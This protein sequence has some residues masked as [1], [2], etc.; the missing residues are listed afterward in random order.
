[1]RSL[2][3]FALSLA[4][5]S[6][7]AGGGVAADLEGLKSRLQDAHAEG[8]DWWVYND[9]E[10]A[11]ETAR[12]LNKPLFVTFRCI[13][14]KDCQA[15]DAEVAKGNEQIEAL[16]REKFVPVRQV[17]MK[18][19]DLSQFQFDYDLNWAAMFIHPD[20][21]VYA[22]YGTQSAEGADAY[23]S[24][25]GLMS[26]MRRVL[27][28]HAAYPGNKDELAAKRGKAKPYKTALEMSGLEN[29]EK[30]RGET[31]RNNCI[32]CH[33]IH[34]AEHRQAWDEGQYSHD[35]LWR[36]PLPENVGLAI[37]A[38]HGVRI[39]W[40]QPGSPAAK[41]GLKAGEDVT[42]MNGQAITSIADM[43]WVLHNLPNTDE[44]AVTVRGSRTG[45]RPL[46]LAAGW[47]KS[48]ISWRGSLWSAPP[49]L[50][51]WMPAAPEEKLR[52]LGLRSD[53]TALEVRWIN[54]GQPGGQAAFA[55]GLRQGDYVV[56]VGGK[57][58]TMTPVEFTMHLKLNYK[59]GDKLPLT[60]VRNGRKQDLEITLTE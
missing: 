19:V 40:V 3:C 49:R 15:F 10:K 41:A 1:M 54:Q 29:K 31:A 20:G 13:P 35:L 27:E 7:W 22:R 14:C 51:V 5:V 44:A 26:T 16:A 59:P 33:M 25:E 43:Q 9:L 38:D 17:E 34:D 30:F 12:R 21:T 18:G 2:G 11:R 6:S 23:N 53:Q 50:T 4:L 46:Q 28:L 56:A 57:P 32:H 39:E 42:H 58:F 48:D 52:Q 37:D 24:V 45:E 36:W 8:E 60:I 47:K 55:A